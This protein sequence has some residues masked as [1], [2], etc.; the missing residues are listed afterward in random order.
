MNTEEQ[1]LYGIANKLVGN[2]GP[3]TSGSRA[4]TGELYITFSHIAANKHEDVAPVWEE[5][6][7]AYIVFQKR[8]KPEGCDFEQEPRFHI[9]WRQVP[10]IKRI[11][12]LFHVWARLLIT[13][14]DPDTKV[15]DYNY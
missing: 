12:G 8:A 14:F 11:D 13:R 4:V 1:K 2:V 10:E 15:A 3:R 7:K 5:W 9:Y 6:V